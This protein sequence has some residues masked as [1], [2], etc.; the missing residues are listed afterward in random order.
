MNKLAS[1]AAATVAFVLAAVSAQG[2]L[3][4]KTWV[5]TAAG[6]NNMGTATNWSPSGAPGN[7]DNGWRLIFGDP[8]SLAQPST[9]GT[10]GAGGWVFEHAGWTLT[11]SGDGIVF[12]INGS[13]IGTGF[14]ESSGV[15]INTINRMVINNGAGA[16]FTTGAGNILSFGSLTGPNVAQRTL[17]KYGAGILAVD[18]GFFRNVNVNAGTLMANGWFRFEGPAAMEVNSGTTLGGIGTLAMETNGGNI[19]INNGATFSP[20]GDGGLITNPIGTFTMSPV[21][22]G[23]ADFRLQTGSTMR[24]DLATGNASDLF[25]LVRSNV[26]DTGSVNLFIQSGVTLDLTGY[27]GVGTYDI[28]RLEGAGTSF[29]SGNVFS[30]VR[31]NG[32]VL[33][34]G[35]HYVLTYTT[36]TSADTFNGG[37]QLTIIPEPATVGLLTGGAL[38][39]L[40]RR[41]RR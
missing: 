20:G 24:V 32:N 37:V 12:R 29:A 33:T 11:A 3:T 26:A 31:L 27:A 41:R 17:N 15:G 8:A 28:I 19:R 40:A 35:E 18:A 36:K 14:V 34:P 7:N 13:A 5:A 1:T 25:R 38:L 39:M 23:T 21:G 2:Q 30:T 22:T 9:T 10:R 16:N 4:D 6:A